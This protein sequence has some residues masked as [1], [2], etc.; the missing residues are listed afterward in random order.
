MALEATARFIIGVS[1][2]SPFI[3]MGIGTGA[4]AE[5]T[6]ST[7]LGTENTQYGAQRA[8]ATLTY[9][10]LGTSQWSILYAFT[11]PVTIRELAIF[12]ALVGGDM[13]LRHVLTEN[14]N[15]ADGES[16]EITITNTMVRVSAA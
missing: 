14:K 10:S 5:S 16:V 7:A 4:G 6:A 9:V 2:P 12:N 3:Y 13:F 1:P 11:G 8:E 15:Y